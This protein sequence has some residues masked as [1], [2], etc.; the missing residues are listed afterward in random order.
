MCEG[1]TPTESLE[2]I[3]HWATLVSPRQELEIRKEEFENQPEMDDELD[4]KDAK[5]RFTRKQICLLS[6]RFAQK[7]TLTSEECSDLATIISLSPLQVKQ[8]G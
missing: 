3:V 2:N 1:L 7:P 5:N 4:G 8:S 6:Q